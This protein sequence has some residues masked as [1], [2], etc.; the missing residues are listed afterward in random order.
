VDSG[1]TE[2]AAGNGLR[3]GGDGPVPAR[4]RRERMLAAVHQRDFVRVADL[5]ER[6]GISEVTVRSDLDALAARGQI[7]R[8]RGGA[9]PRS[10]AAVERPFEETRG[11]FAEEKAAIA[12]HAAAM[13]S[14]HETLI[15]D[16]GT[17]T[18]AIARALA[19]RLDLHDVVVFTN[20]LTIALE[21]E[22]A[23]PRITVVVT[24]GTVRPL[25]HSL[26]DPMG[27]LIL[28]EIHAGTVFL[29]C[30]GV[31][32]DAGVTNV[33][34]PE[35]E[36]KRLMLRSAQRRVVVADGSKVGEVAL[37]PLCGIDDVDLL[38][39]G[40]SADAEIL[41]TLR[42]RGLDVHVAT[43]VPDASVPIHP[44]SAGPSRAE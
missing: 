39:T 1:T 3:A 26:V 19:E 23:T 28:S 15:L 35:A 27:G 17:T 14:N 7:R 32:P 43:T 10:L 44:S 29:G 8:V 6:F 13:V 24:G 22:R 42:D 2:R 18:T 40:A 30:N 37:A 36:V 31:D 41:A 34:L 38:M 4:L 16:V 20:G 11:A 21:L 5:S 12:S 25:Q 9:V 33:N